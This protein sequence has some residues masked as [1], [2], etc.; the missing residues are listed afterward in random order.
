M[1]IRTPSNK[2]VQVS[3]SVQAED[4]MINTECLSLLNTNQIFMNFLDFELFLSVKMV[5]IPIFRMTRD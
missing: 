3:D 4:G 5:I 1:I 2:L